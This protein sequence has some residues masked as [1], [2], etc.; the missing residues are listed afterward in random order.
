MLQSHAL[1]FFNSINSLWASPY[2]I[3]RGKKTH[4]L[5]LKDSCQL[6]IP[7]RLYMQNRSR[8]SGSHNNCTSYIS[9]T[10]YQIP[11]HALIRNSIT[12][13]DNQQPLSPSNIIKKQPISAS[14]NVP[15]SLSLYKYR[16]RGVSRER[17]CRLVHICEE[18]E[19]V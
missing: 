3:S 16:F 8:L 17:K 5:K 1:I 18:R 10:S 2:C 6:E 14:S 15:F 4:G 9:A 7:S 19:S 13:F 12:Y 11:Y